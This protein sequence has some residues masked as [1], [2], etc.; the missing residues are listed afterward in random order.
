[1]RAPRGRAP[2]VPGP[3]RPRAR[4][5][6]SGGAPR[7]LLL[8]GCPRAGGLP[9]DPV[10]GRAPGRARAAPPGDPG[11]RSRSPA[12]PGLAPLALPEGRARGARPMKLAGLSRGERRNTVV[13]AP[14]ARHPVAL[15]F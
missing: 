9:R 7:R 2:E 6:A 13:A 3:V 5:H 10:P 12:A 15:L 4:G 1:A 11:G 8:L 14:V